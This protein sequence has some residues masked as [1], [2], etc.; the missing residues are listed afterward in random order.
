MPEFRSEVK[1][2]KV[3]EADWKYMGEYIFILDMDEDGKI[4]RIVEFLDSKNTMIL[5][6]MMKRA[7][8]NLAEFEKR[9]GREAEDSGVLGFQ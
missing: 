2:K 9:E 8:E 3:N 4:K 5:L 7:R 6:E 1:G